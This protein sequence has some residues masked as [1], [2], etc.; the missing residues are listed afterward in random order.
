MGWHDA[1]IVLPQGL[2]SP[3]PPDRRHCTVLTRTTTTHA[4]AVAALGCHR[5]EARGRAR[6]PDLMLI[7]RRQVAGTLRLVDI[8]VQDHRQEVVEDVDLPVKFDGLAGPMDV[9]REV[10]VALNHQRLRRWCLE[11]RGSAECLC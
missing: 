10:V 3:S 6:R 1:D 9:P 11:L 8:P 2:G 4:A 7:R 5:L